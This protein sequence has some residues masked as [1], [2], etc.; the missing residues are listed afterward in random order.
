MWVIRSGSV[1]EP[2]RRRGS[3]IGDRRPVIDPGDDRSAC[4]ASAAIADADPIPEGDYTTGPMTAEMMAAAV[5]AHGLDP[6]VARSFAENEGFK[7]HEVM[8]MRLKDG[9]LTLLQSLD[10]GTPTVGWM[11][12]MPLPTT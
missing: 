3:A 10:G 4:S 12:P 7:I 1:D 5:E 9:N 11:A 6:D 2:R 8:T